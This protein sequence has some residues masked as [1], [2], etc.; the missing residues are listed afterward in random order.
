MRS[1]ELL[2]EVAVYLIPA[3]VVITIGCSPL[4]MFGLER[5]KYP[6]ALPGLDNV[7]TNALPYEPW[8]M[9]LCMRHSARAAGFDAEDLSGVTV[10]W[11]ESEW[12]TIKGARRCMISG[13]EIGHNFPVAGWYL[14]NRIHVVHCPGQEI[15]ETALP[16]EVIYRHLLQEVSLTEPSQEVRTM[17]EKAKER[18]KT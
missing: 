11:H 6:I 1:R 13:E 3:F 10:A 18:C 14:P 4:I 9:A 15:W 2:K 5:A 12:A 17:I 8:H 16:Y 7:R